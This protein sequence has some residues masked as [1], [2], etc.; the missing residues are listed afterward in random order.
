MSCRDCWMR[1]LKLR[2]SEEFAMKQRSI[3]LILVAMM[4]LALAAQQTPP[5]PP[6]ASTV[7]PAEPARPVVAP[8]P[9]I[10]TFP[11]DLMDRLDR[12][13]IRRM[14]EDARL[15]GQRAAEEAR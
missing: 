14:A 3:V 9:A 12:D 6:P 1:S 5:T 8:L 11:T 4:P 10:S 13:E 7:I 15:M 2:T